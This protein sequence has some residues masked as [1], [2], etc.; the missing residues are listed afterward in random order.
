ME[1]NEETMHY[2]LEEISHLSQMV[3]TGPED[4]VAKML[5]LIGTAVTIYDKIENELDEKTEEIRE[6]KHDLKIATQERDEALMLQLQ[7]AFQEIGS[8]TNQL[9]LHYGDFDSGLC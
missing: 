5:N 9:E 8:L 7:D 3:V 6:L 1:R 2:T 4:Y